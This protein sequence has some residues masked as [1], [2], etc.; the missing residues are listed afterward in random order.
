M[1]IR[2]SSPRRFATVMR[3]DPAGAIAAGF[4]QPRCMGPPKLIDPA[5]SNVKM[6]IGGR[7]GAKGGRPGV[8]PYLSSSRERTVAS[9]EEMP[10]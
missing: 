2:D 1:C 9:W 10:A 7:P 5:R 4:A 8:S 3:F 6:L